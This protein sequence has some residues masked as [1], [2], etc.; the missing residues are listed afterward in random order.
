MPPHG[1]KKSQTPTGS[2]TPPPPVLSPQITASEALRLLGTQEE[3]TDTELLAIADT[4][5]NL[6]AQPAPA[7]DPRPQSGLLLPTH[8]VDF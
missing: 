5:I 8:K 7:A 3:T 6:R 2:A 4:L 1:D